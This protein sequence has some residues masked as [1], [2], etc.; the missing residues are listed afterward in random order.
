MYFYG[1]VLFR[2]FTWALSPVSCQSDHH[3]PC[4]RLIY[5]HCNLCTIDIALPAQL[6]VHKIIQRSTFILRILDN[7]WI[8]HVFH[9]LMA[10]GIG[11]F[12]ASPLDLCSDSHLSKCKT[13]LSS[14]PC[15]S[16]SYHSVRSR[17]VSIFIGTLSVWAN[18]VRFHT[19]SLRFSVLLSR[20]WRRSSEYGLGGNWFT[21][22]VLRD[23][24]DFHDHCTHAL[25]KKEDEQTPD[26]KANVEIHTDNISAT[27]TNTD[28][29]RTFGYL[30]FLVLP[31]AFFLY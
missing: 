22:I 31:D 23:T 12:R 25:P 26:A 13:T 8:W 4:N 20:C 17:L 7:I 6:S 21:S 10:G 5:D 28:Y 1:F 9:Q 19:S 24:V 18:G 11:L 27:S 3:L 2:S 29:R 14:I 16:D 15:F 30:R